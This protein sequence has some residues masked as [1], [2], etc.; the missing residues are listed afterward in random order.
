MYSHKETFQWV[1]VI[2]LPGFVAREDFD[3]AVREASKQKKVDCPTAEY[4][5]FIVGCGWRRLSLLR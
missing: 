4:R 5:L 1:A 3:W 2:R